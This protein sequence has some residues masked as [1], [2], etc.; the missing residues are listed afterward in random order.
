MIRWLFIILF[1]YLVYRLIQGPKRRKNPAIRFHF[2]N[3]GKDSRQNDTSSGRPKLDDIEE[4][5]FED[6]T[7]KSEK[8]NKE[9]EKP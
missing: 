3:F 2:R 1:I 5:E 8:E 6:I 4:A 7:E 9:E